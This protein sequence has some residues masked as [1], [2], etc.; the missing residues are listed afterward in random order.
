MSS[1]VLF[2][3]GSNS[4][5][6]RRSSSMWFN[7][8]LY[9]HLSDWF[10]ESQH[11]VA[12]H[13]A[14]GPGTSLSPPNSILNGWIYVFIS[15]KCQMERA[16]PFQELKWRTLFNFPKFFFAHLFRYEL[17][18]KRK[19]CSPNLIDLPIQPYHLFWT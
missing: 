13:F 7:D 6:L 3:P 4:S 10:A 9:S 15:T 1:I 14:S 11:R 17:G 8:F 2:S 16:R 12:C 5:S 19:A 18:K